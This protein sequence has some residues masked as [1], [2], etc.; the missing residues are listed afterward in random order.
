MSE[1]LL[2]IGAGIETSDR[3]GKRAM[4]HACLNNR[5]AIANILIEN[6]ADINAIDAQGTT[7]IVYACSR[8]ILNLVVTL[9]AVAMGFQG[10]GGYE[11]F[12]TH[13]ASLECLL[14]QFT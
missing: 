7:P 13:Q 10:H 3:N 4:H 2:R 8:G 14:Y 12:L 9:K 1:Y 5:E 11:Y 6:G